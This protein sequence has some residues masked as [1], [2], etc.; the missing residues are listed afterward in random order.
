MSM[1]DEITK[2]IGSLTGQVERLRLAVGESK[3]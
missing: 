2:R 3:D 1:K